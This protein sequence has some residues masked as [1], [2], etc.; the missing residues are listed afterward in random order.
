MLETPRRHV[1]F[2]D[3]EGCDEQ[4]DFEGETPD[5]AFQTPM[6]SSMAPSLS[7][8]LV[9]T[10]RQILR[11]QMATSPQDV[12]LQLELTPA[13]SAER[14]LRL[15]QRLTELDAAIEVSSSTT[16]SPARNTT[17]G[18]SP[19]RLLTVGSGT[20]NCDT[21]NIAARKKIEECRAA[22]KILQISGKRLDMDGYWWRESNISCGKSTIT[23]TIQLDVMTRQ[24]CQNV[25]V[26]RL[27]IPVDC[28]S[29]RTSILL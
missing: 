4:H 6:T 25:E 16:S 14:R 1:R 21:D 20:A 9:A 27:R 28:R 23:H 18:N 29:L 15:R 5:S 7:K 13:K 3:G 24:Y 26:S 12:L 8:A 11:Q 17:P 19:L 2:A 22:T 10:G